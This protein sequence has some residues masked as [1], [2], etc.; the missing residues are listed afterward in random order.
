MRKNRKNIIL[1]LVISL[2]LTMTVPATNAYA[3][4]VLL[5]QG[6]NG[7]EVLQLQ[8]QLQQLGYYSGG[9]DGIFGPGTFSAVI[10]FQRDSGLEADGIVGQQTAQAL[11]SSSTTAGS[12]SASTETTMS[13]DEVLRLQTMLKTIGYYQGGL[14]GDFGPLTR[15][16]LLNFQTDSGLEAD[17]VVGPATL[18]ALQGASAAPSSVSRGSNLNRKGDAVVSL[19]RKYLGTRY[20]WAGSSP[21]GFDCSGFTSYIYKQ[22]GVGLP[23]TSTAQFQAGVQV[24]KPSVGDL[25]FFTTYQRGASHVGI[26][27][28][29]NQFI[30][31]SSGAGKV[32][33]TSL[34]DAYYSK[35]Y[36]GARKVL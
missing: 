32:I 26:Y 6:A 7:N 16:A 11:K 25:V 36:L 17:G 30:H 5:Q 18:K 14:D 27:I 3:K 29:N 8:A 21:G 4:Q 24:S 28:G 13:A 12:G 10:N 35:R 34:S 20:A 2:M 22:L 33:I 15:S 19:A 9:V 31:A 1:G 23:R